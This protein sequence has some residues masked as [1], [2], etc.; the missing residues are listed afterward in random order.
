MKDDVGASAPIVTDVNRDRRYIRVV[1]LS[2][3]MLA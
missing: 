3:Q 1:I 2:K